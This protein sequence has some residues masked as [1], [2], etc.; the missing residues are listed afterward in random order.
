MTLAPGGAGGAGAKGAGLVPSKT[1]FCEFV[2]PLDEGAQVL[3]RIRRLKRSVWASGH[4]HGI[5]EPGQRAAVPWFVTLTYA[6]ADGWR[7]DHMSKAV[8]AF[9][10]WCRRRRVQCRYTWVAEIQPRRLERTGQAAVHYHLI[11]WLPVGLTMPFWDRPTA[12]GRP[13]FWQHGM[14][15]TEVCRAG[16]GY[17]MKY[18][19]KLGEFHRFPKGL[20]LYGIGGLDRQAQSVR[21]WLNLPMWARWSHGV[22]EVARSAGRLVLRATGEVLQSPWSVRVVFGALV[23]RAVG[24]VPAARDWGAHS[25]FPRAI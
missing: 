25:T 4:L 7:A 22:G 12:D 1:S 8:H 2:S 3:R 19:S 6:K 11:A 13:A 15:E 24:A 20:R 10:L 23:V 9:R 16:V 17:L 5:A 18:L 14:S 21:G